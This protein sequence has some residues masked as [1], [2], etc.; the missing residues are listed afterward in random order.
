VRALDRVVDALRDAGQEPT[1]PRANQWRARC[2]AHGGTTATSLSVKGI[3]GSVL[4]HCFA[5]CTTADVAEALGLRMADL[6]DEPR[7]ATYAYGD[8]RVVHRSPDKRFRQSGN[9][10]GHPELYRLDAVRTAVLAGHPVYVVE[11]EK[12]VLALESVGVTA[13]CSPMGAGKWGMVDPTPLHGATVIVVADKDTP[14]R[15]H[16]ADVAES[17]AGHAEVVVV[18]ALVGKDAADHIAADHGVDELVPVEVVA[19]EPAPARLS[20]VRLSDVVPER[21]SWLWPGRIPV[22]KLVTLDGD[23]SLGKSTLALTFAAVVTTGGTWPDASTCT[24]TGDVILLSGE[25]GLADT[26]RPRLDAAGAD[27]TRVHAVQGVTLPDGSLR[28]PTLADVDELHEL[29]T[30]TGARLLIVDVLMAYL[31]SGTDSHKD[32]DIRRVLSRLSTLAD[33]TGCT[34]LLVRHLNKA[35]GGDPMYRGGG[36]IGIVGAAR[37]G[38]LVAK[39]PD[40]E[41]VRVLAC[42]KSNLG[43]EPEGLTYRLTDA[44]AHGVARV[45]WLGVSTHD[46]RALLADHAEDAAERPERDEAVAWLED[47]LTE[48]GRVLSR[49]VKSAAQKER[50]TERTLK[51][52]A[53]ELRVVY[54]EEGFPRRT[55]WC[56]PGQA[57][58]GDTPTDP[59]PR[60]S[61]RGPTVPTGP[62]VPDLREHKASQ[63]A[64]AQSGQWGHGSE[65]RPHCTVCGQ[66]LL[67]DVPGRTVCD[68]RD[69]VHATARLV[70]AA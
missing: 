63:D 9:T 37:A 13:T 56:L 65:R 35:K 64:E 66:M 16:A 17:L 2:P 24:F 53:K 51:R 11:G 19:T 61:E 34:V 12:D 38:M 29:V 48:Q 8:G 4:L 20:V 23:P 60:L 25:D 27:V 67:L 43:P 36:S 26:V 18:E 47:H 5:G 15:K 70:S 58:S 3:E 10:S 28:P 59:D 21:V 54:T 1:E 55:F 14:G 30:E 44:D 62:T 33:S 57:P 42:T 22:G 52:A 41:D 50:I 45:Q 6:F 40:D 69:D 68:A 49:D 39:D 46:A 31:P 7:G 32:Q